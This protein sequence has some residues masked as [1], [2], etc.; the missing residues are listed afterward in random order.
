MQARPGSRV[1]EEDG[2]QRE[3]LED[4]PLLDVF[5]GDR[6][7]L[8]P[9]RD[10]REVER[11]EGSTP[12]KLTW[13]AYYAA[14]EPDYLFTAFAPCVVVAYTCGDAYK[15]AM[16]WVYTGVFSGKG[17]VL[18]VMVVLAVVLFQ[19]HILRIRTRVIYGRENIFRMNAGYVTRR[20]PNGPLELVEEKM[21]GVVAV[22]EERKKIVD[23][24]LRK[25]R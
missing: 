10:M 4:D 19:L 2:A 20:V 1:E 21:M 17:M 6:T 11:G 22:E 14:L 16:T 7:F 13:A 8:D 18:D 15:L 12:W 9:Y 24:K 5:G 25:Y 23:A 3:V